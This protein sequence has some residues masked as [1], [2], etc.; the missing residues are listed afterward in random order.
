MPWVYILVG[1]GGAVA[2]QD[3]KNCFHFRLVGSF[4]FRA[5]TLARRLQVSLVEA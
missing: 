1:R 5:R 3:L 4:A 2:C